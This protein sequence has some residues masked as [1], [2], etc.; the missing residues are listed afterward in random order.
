MESNTGDVICRMNCR[1][2]APAPSQVG[3]GVPAKTSLDEEGIE[4]PN[5]ATNYRK[6]PVLH[7]E[8]PAAASGATQTQPA[9]AQALPRDSLFANVA[10]YSFSTPYNVL[11]RSGFSRS[12]LASRTRVRFAANV[13]SAKRIL[14]RV[15]SGLTAKAADY[16]RKRRAGTLR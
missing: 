2:G 1:G 11:L 12:D 16:F 8:R 14:L 9:R 6:A 7:A 10:S 13:V 3:F 15:M 5:D 4:G